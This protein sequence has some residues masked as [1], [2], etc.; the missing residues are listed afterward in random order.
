MQFIVLK[1]TQYYSYQ[2][3]YGDNLINR[4]MQK[5]A[6]FPLASLVS[7]TITSL[8]GGN[9]GELCG[10]HNLKQ[11]HHSNSFKTQLNWTLQLGIYEHI[12]K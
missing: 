3:N 8:I 1:Y 12:E 4:K 2:Q 11:I 9:E 10:E 6:I 5:F 7:V